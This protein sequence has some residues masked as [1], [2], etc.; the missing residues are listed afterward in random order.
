MLAEEFLQLNLGAKA[1]QIAQEQS[2][3]FRSGHVG[4]RL[5]CRLVLVLF[6]CVPG[7]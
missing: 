5:V 3:V 4:D 2:F 7:C 1:R 6:S